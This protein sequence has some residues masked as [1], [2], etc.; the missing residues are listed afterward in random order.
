MTEAALTIHDLRELPDF[1]DRVAERGWSAWWTDSGVSLAE[2]RAQFE[3]MLSGDGLPLALVAHDGDRYAGSVLLIEDDLSAR[4]Q[5]A[6][7]IAA[8]W[9]EP[10]DRR[11]GLAARLIAAA[12]AEAARL[13]DEVCY[14][15]AEA[16]LRD[17]YL[18]NGFRVIERD[19][20]GLDVFSIG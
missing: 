8:L 3:P 9:V 7:W 13:G 6:P 19:V 5:Y 16:R 4:P 2:Y 15:C 10:E 14:L 11:Q 18:K 17:F 1:V 20:E 12:R